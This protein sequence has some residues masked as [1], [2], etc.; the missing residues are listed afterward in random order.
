MSKHQVQFN[1]GLSYWLKLSLPFLIAISACVPA[2]WLQLNAAGSTEPIMGL[3]AYGLAIVAAAFIL[4][5]IGEAAELDLSGGL[6]VGILAL[7]AILPEYVVSIYFS[8]AAGSD[9]TMVEYATANLTGANRIVQG[10]GWPV[11]ALIAYFSIK[12]VRAR[13][14]GNKKE[15]G[16]A[17]ES[18]SR[19]DIGF[20]ILGSMVMLIVPVAHS[21]HLLTGILLVVIYCVYLWR[22]SG[23]SRSEPEL[24]GTSAYVGA[25]PKWTRRIFILLMLV[26]SATVIF[27]SAHPFGDSLIEAGKAL[28]IDEY[29]L[30]QWLAP[31]ASEAPEFTLAFLFAARGKEGAALAILISSKLNQWT[32]LAGSMPIAYVIGGGENAALPIDSRGAEELWLTTAQT[33]LGVAILLTLRWGMTASVLIL[34]LFLVSVI[35]DETFRNDLG[36][37]HMV[38]A[39]VYFYVNRHYIKPTIK[40]P[41]SKPK[42]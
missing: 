35:P 30:V 24:E 12:S 17:L 26:V 21:M 20:L 39:L 31:V 7:V 33:L 23:S 16:I 13:R 5:W 36:I 15:F 19:A 28:N 8:F 4:G 14:S 27:L 18:D 32:L 9:P 6:A 2:M 25:L 3:L 29:I 1:S 34:G 40:A 38:L 22:I 11:V 42:D 10:F 37:V 41:F